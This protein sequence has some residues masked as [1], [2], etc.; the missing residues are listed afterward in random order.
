MIRKEWLWSLISALE[1]SLETAETEDEK[2]IMNLLALELKD[3]VEFE[4]ISN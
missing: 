3:H 1:L 2:V 4:E